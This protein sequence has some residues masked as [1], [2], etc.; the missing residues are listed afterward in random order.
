MKND[1]KKLLI[2][3]KTGLLENIE[4]AFQLSNS[5]HIDLISFSVKY[6]EIQWFEKVLNSDFIELSFIE[7]IH[8]LTTIQFLDL[9]AIHDKIPS[10]I[11]ELTSLRHLSLQNTNITVLPKEIQQLHQLKTL[12]IG[13]NPLTELP[14]ELG[15]LKQLTRISAFGCSIQYISKELFTHNFYIKLDLEGNNVVPYI[16]P[17]IRKYLTSIQ[18]D[19][20]HQFL[21]DISKEDLLYLL[22]LNDSYHTNLAHK[23]AQEENIIL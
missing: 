17:E 13:Q 21:F 20:K 9:Q 3:I 1:L 22:S 2:L 6:F 4:L 5:Q 14:I 15:Q 16:P 12:N 11:W 7:K 8:Y 10:C 18:L 23:L 19:K